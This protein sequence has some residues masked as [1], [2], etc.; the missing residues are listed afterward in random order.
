MRNVGVTFDVIAIGLAVLGVL[1]AFAIHVFQT[2][3]AGTKKLIEFADGRAEAQRLA[4]AKEDQSAF[5]RI[6]G[7]VCITAFIAILAC[8]FARKI[9][10]I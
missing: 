7:A 4:I 10:L 8:A 1:V 9:H 6:A 3:R 5:R 2:F